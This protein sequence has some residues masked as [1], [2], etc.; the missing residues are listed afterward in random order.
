VTVYEMD[1]A[2]VAAAAAALGQASGEGRLD[3]RAPIDFTVNP[4][5][6][7]WYQAVD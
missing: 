6:I 5:V 1:S 4:P 2:D 7:Q 3:M